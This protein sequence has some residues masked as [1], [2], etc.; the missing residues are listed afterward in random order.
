MLFEN[1][2]NI[3]GHNKGGVV[4]ILLENPRVYFISCTAHFAPRASFSVIQ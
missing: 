3:V 2:A 4:V 1:G